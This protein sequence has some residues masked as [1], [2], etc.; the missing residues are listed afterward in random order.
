M[1]TEAELK[2]IRDNLQVDDENKDVKY[3]DLVEKV[4]LIIKLN[5]IQSKFVEETNEIKKKLAE[6]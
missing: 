6:H 2:Y 4:N 5:D 3:N 1:F